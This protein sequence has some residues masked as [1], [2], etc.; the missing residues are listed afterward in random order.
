M[1]RNYNIDQPNTN[2]DILESTHPN[3][4]S[5]RLCD[6]R[7]KTGYDN[8]GCAPSTPTRT[9]WHPFSNCKYRPNYIKYKSCMRLS[10]SHQN[11]AAPLKLKFVLGASFS[12]SIITTRQRTPT[13]KLHSN[14]RGIHKYN[15]TVT[16]VLVS[17]IFFC[18]TM[19]LSY[20][21]FIH[22]CSLGMTPPCLALW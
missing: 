13:L 1:G 2:V 14:T 7:T 15:V 21:K 9:S 17:N 16:S 18:L 10:L 3:N 19:F 22:L 8:S 12:R 20:L 4:G 5:N 6:D 11:F